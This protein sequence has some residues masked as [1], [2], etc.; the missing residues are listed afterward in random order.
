M[1]IQIGTESGTYAFNHTAKTVAITGL[2]AALTLDEIL[3]VIHVPT[4]TVLYQ[5]GVIGLAATWVPSGTGGTLTLNSSLIT[6]A[7]SDADPLCIQVNASPAAYSVTPTAVALDATVQASNTLLTAISTKLPTLGTHNTAGSMAVNI[8]SDQVVPIS[9]TA[10]PLPTGA[11]TAALQTSIIT[12]LGSP[13]QNGGSVVA[14]IGSSGLGSTGT[15]ITM[16]DAYQAPTTATWTSATALNTVVFQMTAGY[17]GTGVTLI[18]T[19][20]LSGGAIT[21]EIFDGSSWLP[22]KINRLNTYQGDATFALTGIT[23]GGTQAWQADVAPFSQFRVRLSTV[24]TGAGSVLVTLVSSSATVI[25]PVT[26]GLD[27]TQPLPTGSNALGSVTVTTLPS[28]PAGANAIGSVVVTTLP[29][30]PTG[31]NT[32][33][34][35]NV[36]GGNATAVKVDGS[37]VTQ[38]ISAA[39]LPLPAGAATQTTLA[40]ISAQLPASLGAKATAA[41]V[42]V[43]IASD[44]TVPVSAASLPLPTGAATSAL[45]TT[46]NTSIQ[47][48]ANAAQTVTAGVTTVALITA[49]GDA[50]N[51]VRRTLLT[52]MGE[53]IAVG[54]GEFF[55]N[56][57]LGSGSITPTDGTNTKTFLVQP[58]EADAFVYFSGLSSSPT[59]QLSGSY[60]GQLWATIPLTRFD[61]TAASQQF[62]TTSVFTPTQYAVYRGKTYGYPL[63]RAHLTAGTS[64][65]TYGYVRVVPMTEDPG[66][67]VS[68]FTLT[69][70][71]TTESV[72]NANGTTGTGGVRTIAIPVRGATKAEIYIDAITWA[73]TMSAGVQFVVEGNVDPSAAAAATTWNLLTISPT[74]G[75]LGV[76]TITSST[77]TSAIPFSGK[78]E[79]DCSNYAQIRV[80]MTNA[81][82]GGA[83][84]YIFGGI[85]I[86]PVSAPA[87]GTVNK[88]SHSATATGVTATAATNVMVIESAATKSVRVRRLRI[89][90][91]TATAAG[92]GTLTIYRNTVA[93]SAAGTLITNSAIA[94]DPG[95][96]FGGVVRTSGFTLTGVTSTATSQ[97][98]Q[99]AVPTTLGQPFDIDLTDGGSMAALLN[100]AGT[101]NGVMFQVS[102]LGTGAANFGLTADFTEE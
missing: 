65:N 92:T 91:G 81:G 23:S 43:N 41:S 33:G 17:D 34:S 102:N 87:A 25:G 53:Q 12:T 36:L 44:Q 55:G 69:A 8:A 75:G 80:R 50:I 20:V 60:D 5:I 73:G 89:Q 90:P 27:P 30:L 64:T 47:Q 37:A 1:K 6:T 86:V 98:I 42:A 52:G 99:F 78:W 16:A 76:T 15:P 70:V 54:P 61:N 68:P 59:F 14:Q 31:A 66:A 74:V 38:P 32:I 84:P 83:G 93:A 45:Q 67:T 29:A 101:F 9:A 11:A 95:Q 77:G 88:S 94:R 79:T 28:I 40:A 3:V 39:A 46:G 58:R 7:M 2:T 19:G 71:N 10:L 97:V 62:T 56:F 72:G 48:I 96:V 21:F 49:G 22:A 100:Q 4:G 51:S 85:K 18:G 82:T 63:L 26:V 35:V 24:I 13:L 57:S